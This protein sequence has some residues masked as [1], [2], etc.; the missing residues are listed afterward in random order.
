M[1][2]VIAIAIPL[3]IWA[4]GCVVV[5]GLPLAAT[6]GLLVWLPPEL[7]L[8]AL[9]FD[10]V[11]AMLEALG[12]STRGYDHIPL[13]DAAAMAP[14]FRLSI[15]AC[16]ILYLLML[17]LH[18]LTP[19]RWQLRAK[20]PISRIAAST[21]LYKALEELASQHQQ[22]MPSLW[23]LNSASINAWAYS[24]PGGRRAVVLTHGLLS[25]LPVDQIRWVFAHELGHLARGDAAGSGFWIAGSRCM[26]L[27]DRLRM[28]TINL[29]LRTMARTPILYI[30]VLPGWLIATIALGLTRTTERLLRTLLVLL[31]RP[32]NR[33]AEFRADAYATQL[34]GPEPGIALLER[35][36]LSGGTALADLVGSHPSHSRRVARLRN[37]NRAAE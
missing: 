36:A 34:V 12:Q 1:N 30:F 35:L 21:P 25:Q 17:V 29:C 5:V 2:R 6:Y 27:L 4:A 19:L 14:V 33:H 18:A 10:P 32:W 22:P 13:P 28:A 24:A 16:V 9:V 11:W 20:G 31:S 23:L 15:A 37:Q 8:P 26:G 3:S 7:P